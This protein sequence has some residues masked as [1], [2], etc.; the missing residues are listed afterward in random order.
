MKKRCS[1][2]GFV[3]FLLILASYLTAGEWVKSYTPAIAHSNTD[4]ITL[5]STCKWIKDYSASGTEYKPHASEHTTSTPSDEQPAP[6]VLSNCNSLLVIL[7]G[8][9]QY[10][11]NPSLQ[12]RNIGRNGPVLTS[13][14]F[15]FQEPDPPRFI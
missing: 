11:I 13:Q 14:I 15:V 9:H 8:N 6:Q 4:H 3:L 12:D 5:A 2:Y 1:K 7:P 10:L